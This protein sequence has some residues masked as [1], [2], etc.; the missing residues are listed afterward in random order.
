LAQAAAINVKANKAEPCAGPI[1]KRFLQSTSVASTTQTRYYFIEIGWP[2]F[3]PPF[4]A[5]QLPNIPGAEDTKRIDG[6]KSC[7]DDF[8]ALTSGALAAPGA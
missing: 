6:I 2:L 1:T 3:H 8:F 7:L 4:F 5:R